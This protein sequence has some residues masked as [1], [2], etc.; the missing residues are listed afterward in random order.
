MTLYKVLV[1]ISLASITT[2][3]FSFSCLL[4]IIIYMHIDEEDSGRVC[5]SCWIQRWAEAG[6]PALCQ[7]HYLKVACSMG[8]RQVRIQIPIPDQVIYKL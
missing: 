8:S 5:V 3:S 6:G 4:I 7:W 1:Q 2:P